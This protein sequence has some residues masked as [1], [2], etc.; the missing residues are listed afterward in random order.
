VYLSSRVFLSKTKKA[1]SGKFQNGISY[2]FHPFLDM[3]Q[4]CGIRQADV[5]IVPEISSRHNSHVGFIE[6]IRGEI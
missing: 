4:G 6:E 1:I 5:F 3:A 2:P